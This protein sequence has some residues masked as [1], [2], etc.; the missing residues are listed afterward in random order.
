MKKLP[1][2]KGQQLENLGKAAHEALASVT[3]GFRQLMEAS[4][5]EDP[6]EQVK[7]RA[8]YIIEEARSNYETAL[9]EMR[10][11]DDETFARRGPPSSSLPPLLSSRSSRC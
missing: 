9:Q 3:V 4:A 5:H 11:I 6:R 1:S 10:R 8:R 2:E 7:T